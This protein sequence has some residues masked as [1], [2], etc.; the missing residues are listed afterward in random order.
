MMIH[1]SE[2][3]AVMAPDFKSKPASLYFRGPHAVVQ[4]EDTG[5]FKLKEPP[6]TLA[7]VETLATQI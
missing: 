1:P 4:T 5:E 7:E 3:R 6:T 2:S